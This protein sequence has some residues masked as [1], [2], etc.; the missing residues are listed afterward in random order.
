MHPGNRKGKN[1]ASSFSRS[2]RKFPAREGA[3]VL[4]PSFLFFRM[5]NEIREIRD[6]VRMQEK[7]DIWSKRYRLLNGITCARAYLIFARRHFSDPD[8]EIY[9]D[10]TDTVLARI[11]RSLVED[12][13]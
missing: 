9:L 3:A 5:A 8:G 13:E 4:F 11:A 6:W 2:E 1:P 7:R 12:R 10:L